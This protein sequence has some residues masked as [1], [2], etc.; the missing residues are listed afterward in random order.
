MKRIALIGSAPSSVRRAPYSDPSWTIWACSPGAIG[1]VSRCDRFF[2]I[3]GWRPENPCREANYV[4]KL[5]TLTCPIFMVHPVPELPTSVPYPKEE[6][7]GYSYGRTIDHDGNVRSAHFDPTDFSSSLSW[8]LAM[9]IMERPDEIGLWG[10]DMSAQEEWHGQRS[11]CQ[12]LIHIAK[13]IGIKIT[14][15]PESDLIRPAPLYGYQEHDHYWVKLREALRE[16][17]DR[18]NDATNRRQAAH[19]EYNFLCGA[20]D[21]IVYDMKTWVGDNQALGMA[22]RGPLDPIKHEIE[23][24]AH[25][26]IEAKP[27][28]KRKSKKTKEKAAKPPFVNGAEQHSSVLHS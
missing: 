26:V 7:L 19:D 3:H 21:R 14:L 15:P 23:A 17:N 25:P 5:K 18:I 2:E 4:N 8:M 13:S 12:H 10:V 24:T 9:A 11:G 27:E 6:V 16:V 22:Y 1:F 28:R 20:R